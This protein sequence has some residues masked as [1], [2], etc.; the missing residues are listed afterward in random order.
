MKPGIKAILEKQIDQRTAEESESLSKNF[1]TYQRR[2]PG[3]IHNGSASFFQGPEKGEMV[4]V[5]QKA[6][7][8]VKI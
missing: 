4:V 7:E 6:I 5:S 1:K 3:L 8:K 2:F